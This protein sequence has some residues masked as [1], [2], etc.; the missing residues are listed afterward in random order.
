MNI[1]H[2]K[3]KWV[4]LLLSAS[5]TLT[6]GF[7]WAASDDRTDPSERALAAEAAQSSGQAQAADTADPAKQGETAN[8]V[9][10]A[11]Q[12]QA[13]DAADP[14]KQSAE[15]AD[16]A[17][18]GNQNQKTETTGSTGQGSQTASNGASSN[19]SAAPSGTITVDDAIKQALENNSDL[20]AMRIDV[21]TA[22]T[23][24]RLVNAKVRD[25]PADF[26]TTLDAAQQ[27][28]VN[29]AKAQSAKEVNKYA[30]KAAESKTKL[31]AQKAYYDLLNAQADVELKQRSLDRAKEQVRMAQA[32][33]QVGTKAKTDVLQAEAA[34]A[35][36]EAALAGAKSTL[37]QNRLKF[38]QFIGADLDKQW[39]LKEDALNQADITPLNKAI[40]LALQ[41]RAEIMQSQEE[42]KV[43][44][45]NIDLIRKYSSIATYQGEMS[46]NDL[47]KAK[48]NLEQ[49]KKQITVDVSVAYN[50][51]NAAK[52]AV[53]AYKKA[54]DASTENYRLVKLRFQN[55]L[56]TIVDVIQA[57]ETLRNSENQYQAGIH[58]YNIAL[59]NYNNVMG[60]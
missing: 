21:D 28:Y 36:A 15:A 52:S 44:E 33:F 57:E 45:L 5:I 2:T 54:L 51:L 24:A 47:E 48:L 9:D 22:D 23:N 12:D 53:E 39:N 11:R 17:G 35:T 42:I 27:K 40:E 14:A 25:I 49:I 13:A 59:A 18:T 60:N 20:K 32:A 30:L 46:Q 41:Q 43:A 50:N 26:V 7:A 8:P 56:S 31:G 6:A 34:Q 16:A 55:G 10:A 19:Q 4:F 37:E 38:N 1:L 58:N 29:N 3:Q